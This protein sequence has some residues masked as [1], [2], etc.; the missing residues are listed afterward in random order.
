ML[1]IRITLSGLIC[2][3]S[4]KKARSQTA[5][6]II[7]KH[8]EVIGGYEKIK[9]IKSIVF[10]GT[11]K[12]P[13]RERTFKSYIIHDSVV[14]TENTDNGI[15]GYGIVTKK[16]GWTYSPAASG[17]SVKKK[18]KQEVKE[19]QWILDLHGPLIDYE[20]KGNKI[21]YLGKE[22][23]EG[24]KCFKLR[25]VKSNKRAFTYYFD[26]TYLISRVIYLRHDWAPEFTVDHYYKKLDEGI[27]FV[28]KSLRLEDGMETTYKYYLINPEIDRSLFIARKP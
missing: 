7:T 19:S 6:E 13:D 11:S 22:E 21:I 20:K 1:V 18:S 9:H 14:R 28:I 25:L 17:T 23:I 24:K 12:F 8:I 26:S 2:I 3:F 15:T 5:D 10:E 16:E 4:F 27:T